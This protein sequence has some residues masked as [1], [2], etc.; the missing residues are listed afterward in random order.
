MRKKR[1]KHSLGVLLN[2]PHDEENHGKYTNAA[3][4]RVV[5]EFGLG[6]LFCGHNVSGRLRI[7]ELVFVGAFPSAE[8]FNKS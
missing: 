6:E 5:E 1:P 3:K 8:K 2:V 4:M 7:D